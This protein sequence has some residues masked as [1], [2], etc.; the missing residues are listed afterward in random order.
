[1]AVFCKEQ[2]A[3]G[4]RSIPQQQRPQAPI[5]QQQQQRPMQQRPQAPIQQQQQRPIQ[6]QQQPQALIQ[7]QQ[8]LP[9]QAMIEQQQPV[10][11]WE[12]NFPVVGLDMTTTMSRS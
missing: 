5:Q 2:N 9:P 4:Q 3:G 11:E 7:Q 8:R 1:M 12:E 10:L 6:Q